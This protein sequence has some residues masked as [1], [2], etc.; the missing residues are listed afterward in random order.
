MIALDS[1]LILGG[2][3]FVFVLNTLQEKDGRAEDSSDPDSDGA[4]CRP[5]VSPP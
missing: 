4:G 3:A 1:A 2:P 5:P